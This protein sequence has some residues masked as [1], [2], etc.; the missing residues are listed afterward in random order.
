M[1]GVQKMVLLCLNLALFL[2][3]EVSDLRRAGSEG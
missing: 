2:G 1:S 3:Q